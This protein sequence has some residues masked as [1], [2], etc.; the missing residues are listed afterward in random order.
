MAD[1]W[2]T[3]GEV[4]VEHEAESVF[5]ATGQLQ[6]AIAESLPAKLAER[7]MEAIS[8]HLHAEK[9]PRAP[10]DEEE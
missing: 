4:V 6:A 2:A 1:R 3:S 9:I 10:D 5:D 8:F 7:G